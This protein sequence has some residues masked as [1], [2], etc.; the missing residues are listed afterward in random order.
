M[1]D[2]NM[3]SIPVHLDIGEE[4]GSTSGLFANIH[5][6]EYYQNRIIRIVV[7]KS[8]PKIFAGL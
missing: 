4:N 3:L 5:G 8:N 1:L 6:T 2:G 7:R